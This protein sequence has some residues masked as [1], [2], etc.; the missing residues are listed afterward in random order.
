[1]NGDAWVTY[2]SIGD[3]SENGT[4]YTGDV[5]IPESITVNDKVY[6]VTKIDNYAFIYCSGVTSITIPSSVTSIGDCAFLDC[7][8]LSTI[9]I[10]NSVKEMGSNALGGTAWYDNQPDGMV[11]AGEIAYCYKGT[12]P[13]YTTITL[14]GGTWGI[15]AGAFVNC[16]H[17]KSISIPN[18]VTYIGKNAFQDCHNLVSIDIPNGVNIINNYTFYCCWN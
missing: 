10:P 12:M 5:V 3:L 16:I 15:A 14:R 13:P 2:G 9:I 18:S 1:M 4:S 11:Y 17:L 6:N 8:S 7:S